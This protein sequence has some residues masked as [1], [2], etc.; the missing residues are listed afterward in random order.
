MKRFVLGVV[1]LMMAGCTPPKGQTT[2]VPI[3]NDCGQ[4]L[5]QFGSIDDAKVWI[6][7]HKS[8]RI[9]TISECYGRII[10]VCE[11]AK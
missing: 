2:D 1:V 4:T 8:N 3:S 7:E 5:M 9:V 10:L 6:Q 11:T